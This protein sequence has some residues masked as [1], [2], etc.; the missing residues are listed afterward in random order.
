MP[1]QVFVTKAIMC[2]DCIPFCWSNLNQ[3]NFLLYTH[4]TIIFCQQKTGTQQFNWLVAFY[5]FLETSASSW[6]SRDAGSQL[7]T[8]MELADTGATGR[9][10]AVAT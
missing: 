3:S 7:A 5:V 1:P 4:Q 10:G 9:L 6:W 2:D 8:G